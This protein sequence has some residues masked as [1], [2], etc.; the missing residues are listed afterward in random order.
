MYWY[1]LHSLRYIVSKCLQNRFSKRLFQNVQ[2]VKDTQVIIL[3]ISRRM[4][5]HDAINVLV[6]YPTRFGIFLSPV[7]SD[8]VQFGPDRYFLS[9]FRSDSV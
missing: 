1:I 6:T 7:R 8:P 5:I 3:T 2:E 4:Q 9:P